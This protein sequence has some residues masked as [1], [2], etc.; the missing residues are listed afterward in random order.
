MFREPLLQK[1][2][3][4]SYMIYDIRLVTL[5][6]IASVTMDNDSQLQVPWV[7]N[8]Y[9]QVPNLNVSIVYVQVHFIVYIIRIDKVVYDGFQFFSLFLM[10]FCY[11]VTK[12]QIDI[13]FH[14]VF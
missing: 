2:L 10:V 13:T 7:K 11:F 3:R 12:I 6:L 4:V 14:F 8:F 9:E 5:S 1:A